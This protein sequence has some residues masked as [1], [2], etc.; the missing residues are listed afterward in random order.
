MAPRTGFG[1][2][3]IPSHDG[4]LGWLWKDFGWVEDIK[5]VCGNE[6]AGNGVWARAIGEEKRG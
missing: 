4:L 5:R 6:G 2:K 1:H 3:P